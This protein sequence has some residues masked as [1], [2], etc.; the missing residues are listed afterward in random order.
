VQPWAE[1]VAPSDGQAPPSQEIQTRMIARIAARRTDEVGLVELETRVLRTTDRP[2]ERG[3]GSA[4]IDGPP[5]ALDL[6][7]R[8]VVQSRGHQQPVE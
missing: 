8:G 4:R 5:Q 6:V 2:G 3:G 7:R 1:L